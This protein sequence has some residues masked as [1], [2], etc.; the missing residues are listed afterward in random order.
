MRRAVPILTLL[1][2]GALAAAW[3]GGGLDALAAWASQQQRGVQNA[4]AGG[5]RALRAGEPGA[6]AALLGLCFAYG[7]AHAAG[8]GH[9]KVLIGGYAAASRV[10]AGRAVAIAVAASLA[11]ATT[12][13]ALVYAG[14][15]LLGWTREAVAGAAD[16]WLAPFSHAAIGLVGLWLVWRGARRLWRPGGERGDRLHHHAHAAHGHDHHEGCGHRHGPSAEEIAAAGTWREAAMLIAGVAMRPCAGALF[17]L[18]LTWGMA[19]PLAGIL[20]AYAM[21]LGVAA[22]T[23][24]AALCGVWLRTGL[25]VSLGGSSAGRVLLPVLELAVG[26]TVAAVALGLL[27]AAV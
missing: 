16:A 14:V 25:V 21:G 26:I 4:L 24:A 5:L 6:L 13:V 2:L 27:L 19:I 8:P 12:A 22:I 7:L 10:P 1:A 17:L 11:Q 18:A 15:V 3:A 20:G 9:G 23:V